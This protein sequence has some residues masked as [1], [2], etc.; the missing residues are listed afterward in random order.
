MSYAKGSVYRV[1]SIAAQI[2]CQAKKQL[3]LEC[4]FVVNRNRKPFN[5]TAES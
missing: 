2:N 3:K 5:P 4:G 1:F